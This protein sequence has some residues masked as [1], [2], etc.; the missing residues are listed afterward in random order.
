MAQEKPIL[1]FG[2]THPLA[3]NWRGNI[4]EHVL[5]GEGFEHGDV[6]SDKTGCSA[7]ENER[8]RP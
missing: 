3:G 2:G 6:D 7:F 1:M 4:S 5:F 8:K